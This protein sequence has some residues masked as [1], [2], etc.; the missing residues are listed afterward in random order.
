MKSVQGLPRTTEQ[1]SGLARVSQTWG[2]G[3]VCGWLPGEPRGTPGAD[4]SH[5]PGCVCLEEKPKHISELVKL[6]RPFRERV[7]G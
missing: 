7:A 6:L 5:G 1:G 4:G 2:C 3:E